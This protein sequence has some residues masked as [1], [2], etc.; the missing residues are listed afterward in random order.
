MNERIIVEK[1]G[2]V[3][4]IPHIFY[5]CI[6][7]DSFNNSSMR[8]KTV[9]PFSLKHGIKDKSYQEKQ[10]FYGGKMSDMVEISTLHCKKSNQRTRSKVSKYRR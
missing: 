7:I 1:A 5:D 6:K 9:L 4:S 10:N 3:I 2:K 8:N